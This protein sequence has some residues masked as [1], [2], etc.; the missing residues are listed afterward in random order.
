MTGWL[1]PRDRAAAESVLSLYDGVVA[2]RLVADAASAALI[3]LASNVFLAT[4]IAFANELARV[5]E[6]YGGDVRR[7]PMGSAWTC[8]SAAAR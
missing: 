2:P 5:V 3:K 6:A 8:G 7:S 1:E 4:K